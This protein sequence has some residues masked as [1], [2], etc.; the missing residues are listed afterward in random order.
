MSMKLSNSLYIHL[1]RIDIEGNELYVQLVD[2]YKKQRNITE[3]LKVN[4]PFEWVRE[5][6]NINNCIEELIIKEII[7]I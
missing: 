2:D 4:K 7:N 6:N 5:M 3:E 1:H